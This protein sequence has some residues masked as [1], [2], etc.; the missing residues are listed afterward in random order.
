[1]KI[2]LFAITITIAPS[3][4][5]ADESAHRQA[6]ECVIE[7]NQWIQAELDA[8]FDQR[9]VQGNY[10]ARLQEYLNNIR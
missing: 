2:A 6:V 7:T 10:N 1:M 3:I 5:F 8:G 4:A 9:S